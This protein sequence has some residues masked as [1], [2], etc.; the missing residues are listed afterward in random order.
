MK[1][2]SERDVESSL[3]YNDALSSVSAS[4]ARSPTWRIRAD[5]TLL[6]SAKLMIRLLEILATPGP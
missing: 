5:S 3:M 6:G 2:L 4:S 1:T